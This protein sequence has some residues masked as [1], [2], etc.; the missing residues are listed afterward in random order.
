MLAF[1]Y[2]GGMISNMNT[3]ELED[4]VYEYGHVMYRIGRM[5]TDEKQTIKEYTKLVTQKE[6]IVEQFK[7]YFKPAN[8]LSKTLGFVS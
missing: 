1:N 5:E 8:K 3:N 4:L 2:L 7:T 6:K